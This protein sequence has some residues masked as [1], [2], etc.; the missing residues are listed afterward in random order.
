[1]LQSARADWKAHLNEGIRIA[2]AQEICGEVRSW[3]AKA[4]RKA[5]VAAVAARRGC[6]VKTTG[7]SI[8]QIRH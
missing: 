8:G 1:M 7:D 2:A 3:H 4:V 6:I 5:P